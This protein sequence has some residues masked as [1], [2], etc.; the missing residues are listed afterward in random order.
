MGLVWLFSA[1][2]ETCDLIQVFKVDVA[3]EEAGLFPM[4]QEFL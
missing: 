3:Y 1:E 2:I 4:S